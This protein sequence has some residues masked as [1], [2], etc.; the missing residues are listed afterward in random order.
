MVLVAFMLMLLASYFALFLFIHK[1]ISFGHR[2]VE[3]RTV[4]ET[5]AVA[6]AM[7]NEED[8]IIKCLNSLNRSFGFEHKLHV[9]LVDDHSTDKSVAQ[10]EKHRASFDRLNI[11]LIR[12][13][14]IGKK[15]AL[16]ELLPLVKESWCYLTD[17]DCEVQSQ[18]IA[19]LVQKSK[20][21]MKPIVYGP[22]HYNVQS[23]IGGLM[24][25]ENLNTQLVGEALL[26]FGRP[27]MVNGA[28]TL[29][30]ASVIPLFM[31]RQNLEYASGDDVF[32]SQTLGREGYAISYDKE[33]MVTTDPPE[34]LGALFSQR[35]RWA[36]KYS[37]YSNGFYR[38]FPAFVFVQN[39]SFLLLLI[40]W[41]LIGFE[42]GAIG[43]LLTC[44]W[45]IEWSF[46]SIWF[47]KYRFQASLPQSLLLTILQPIHI[48][49]VGLL[50]LTKFQVQWKGR[51][52]INQSILIK[53]M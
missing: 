18:T 31:E 13:K 38:F 22:V 12:A 37:G 1:F 4:N 6:I 34:S 16:L 42:F 17:A 10:V 23:F 39:C 52:V 46:H 27:A 44:K 20:S 3:V 30:S 26:N 21:E 35:I 47:R 43:I 15:K 11:T 7:R 45:L 32:F 48:T 14:D 40:Y 24:A 25:Y 33:S 29:M 9:Y 28:N 49:C 53:E 36:S 19:M 51:E 41:A 2:Q 5:V 8:R 50:S